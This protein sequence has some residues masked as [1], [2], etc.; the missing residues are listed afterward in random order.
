MLGVMQFVLLFRSKR[1]RDGLIG[2]SEL[3]FRIRELAS[4]KRHRNSWVSLP[5]LCSTS[6]EL[7][8]GWRWWC[9]EI[10][11][12]EVLPYLYVNYWKCK[13]L[14]MSFCFLLPLPIEFLQACWFCLPE[15][16]SS[17]NSQQPTF[18]CVNFTPLTSNRILLLI[19]LI[20]FMFCYWHYVDP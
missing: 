18:L 8:S 15:N 13:I 3:N 14:L 2:A 10:L 6:C 16:C 19:G 9:Q 4:V 5:N 1:L 17:N 20:V 11:E 12:L 7:K